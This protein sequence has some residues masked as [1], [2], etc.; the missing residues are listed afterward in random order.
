MLDFP[1]VLKETETI[2]NDMYLQATGYVSP[3]SASL[4]TGTTDSSWPFRVMKVPTGFPRIM[5]STVSPCFNPLAIT[6]AVPAST[7]STA[8]FSWRI[9]ASIYSG[10]CTVSVARHTYLTLHASPPN[11]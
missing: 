9:N 8:D 10:I 7:A 4:S 6:T 3:S 2:L 11:T 5:S 1:H